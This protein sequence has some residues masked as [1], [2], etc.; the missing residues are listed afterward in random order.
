MGS[1][2]SV[3]AHELICSRNPAAS[4]RLKE[5]EAAHRVKSQDADYPATRDSPTPADHVRDSLSVVDQ[6]AHQVIQPSSDLSLSPEVK[7]LVHLSQISPGNAS[8]SAAPEQ[9]GRKSSFGRNR[10]PYQRPLGHVRGRPESTGLPSTGASHAQQ[11][12]PL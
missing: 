5:V 2:Q 10:A 3:Q 6:A 12:S 11:T 4:H 8:S 7:L 9:L 1:F